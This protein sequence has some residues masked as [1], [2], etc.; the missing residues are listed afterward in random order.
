MY[1]V[2]VR[3]NTGLI[4]IKDLIGKLWTFKSNRKQQQVN[5]Y[6][7]KLISTFKNLNNQ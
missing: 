6:K 2:L 7:I 3:G 4:Q 1:I 5:L